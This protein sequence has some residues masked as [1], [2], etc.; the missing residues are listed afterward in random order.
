MLENKELEKALNDF[1]KYVI[2][3]SRSNLTRMKKNASKRLYNSIKGEYKHTKKDFSVTF[4]MLDY[5]YY[6]DKGV[7]GK[8]KKYPGVKASYTNKMPPPS[9]L[10]K[11]TIRKGIAPRDSKGKFITRKALTFLI[12]R[13]IYKNGIKPSLFFTKPFNAAVK[14]LPKELVDSFGLDIDKFLKEI[15][16]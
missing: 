6:Q 2:K 1:K 16:K 5:G 8:E 9:K 12:A 11:W 14:R 15:N 7:N 4:E 3:E 10:D 13:G